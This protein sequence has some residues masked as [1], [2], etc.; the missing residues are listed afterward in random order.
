MSATD[1]PESEYDKVGDFYINWLGG[2]D[3]DENI[4]LDIEI[5][6]SMLGDID[7]R[8]VCDLGCGEGFLSRILAS[9]G[10]RVRGIDISRILLGYARRHPQQQNISYILDDA[11]SLSR[12]TTAS[13]DAVVCNMALIDIPDLSATL[14]AVRRVLVDGGTFVFQILHPCFFT[15]FNAKNPPEEMDSDGNFIAARTTRYSVEGKWYSN[16]TGMCGTLGSHH[17][18]LSTYLNTL[19]VN[20]LQLA[21]LYE[22]IALAD[23]TAT[24][25]Q[26]ESVVPTYMIAKLTAH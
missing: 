21:E 1:L 15:P 4:S 9:R 24:V 6:L 10:A 22:P 23:T 11:Q 20:G 7:G 14:S 19:V 18:M 2:S 16:G 5:M 26:R 3:R 17:R 8:C 13:M 12:I 25:R